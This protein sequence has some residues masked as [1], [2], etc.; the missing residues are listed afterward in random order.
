MTLEEYKQSI[1]EY[2][3]FGIIHTDLQDTYSIGFRNGIRWCKSL[4]NE[5][6][7]I[8]ES[9]ANTPQTETISLQGGEDVH[10]FCK[11]C[12]ESRVRHFYG[13]RYIVCKQADDAPSICLKKCPLSKWIAEDVYLIT[14]QTE[15][16]EE[17]E[18]NAD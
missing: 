9:T 5:V 10:N 2:M 8:Y 18:G 13:E 3:D 12:K 16:S 11:C 17:G 6:E 7:P 15:R 14:P 4:I 1:I